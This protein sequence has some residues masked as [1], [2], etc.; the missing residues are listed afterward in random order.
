MGSSHGLRRPPHLSA[1]RAPALG[2]GPRSPPRSPVTGRGLR[3]RHHGE[4]RP[5]ARRRW[6]GDVR[7][8][9]RHLRRRGRERGRVGVQV[10]PAQAPSLARLDPRL[11]SCGILARQSC[12]GFSRPPRVEAAFIRS[13]GAWSTRRGAGCW[14]RL[15]G[16]G[17]TPALREFAVL[18]GAGGGRVPCDVHAK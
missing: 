5:T 10:S 8:L 2:S 16:P 6:P 17:A 14:G 3:Q 1:A 15:G 7:A 18:G 9:G 11:G 4:Y 12:S 13:L